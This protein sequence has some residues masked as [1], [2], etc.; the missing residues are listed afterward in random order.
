MPRV[1]RDILS[2][3]IAG[4]SDMAAV[5]ELVGHDRLLAEVDRVKPHVVVL[6]LQDAEIPRTCELLFSRAPDM[7]IIAIEGT[8]HRA[9]LYELRPTRTLLGEP[10]LRGFLELI[11]SATRQSDDSPL[12]HHA[13]C[14]SQ[15]ERP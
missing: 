6:G 2:E 1:L 11:R 10:S 4:E 9:T 13:G 8:G 15:E 14:W 12:Q 3:V 5:G 7:K